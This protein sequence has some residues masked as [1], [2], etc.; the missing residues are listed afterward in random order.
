MG[1]SKALLKGP[2]PLIRETTNKVHL[3]S[4]T[5]MN[6]W[7][8]FYYIFSLFACLVELDT[9]IILNFLFLF[10]VKSGRLGESGTERI[11]LGDKEGPVTT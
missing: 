2:L 1:L 3:L 5:T 6:N 7:H 4:Y 8:I 9:A 10:F 11:A